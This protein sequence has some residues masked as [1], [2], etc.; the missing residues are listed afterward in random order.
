MLQ[1]RMWLGGVIYI[2]L[3]VCLCVYVAECMRVCILVFVFQ[4]P[5]TF[6]L[7]VFLQDFYHQDWKTD[8]PVPWTSY[9]SYVQD[10]FCKS[11]SLLLETFDILWS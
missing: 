3:C 2:T 10:I 11:N 1:W 4:N 9:V 8:S 6:F 5:Q 7:I